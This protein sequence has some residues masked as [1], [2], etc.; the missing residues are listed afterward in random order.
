MII[1]VLLMTL[2]SVL[3]SGGGSNAMHGWCHEPKP[4][5][6]LGGYGEDDDCIDDDDDDE[7]DDIQKQF[8]NDNEDNIS[9]L[10]FSSLLIFFQRLC[11]LLQPDKEVK[12]ATN[13]GTL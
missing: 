5:R 12:E 4:S 8:D 10:N 1:R 3:E 2:M 9:A 13:S 11:L 6:W 7:Y